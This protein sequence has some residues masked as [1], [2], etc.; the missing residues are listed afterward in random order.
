MT[1]AVFDTTTLLQ[2][3]TS[4]KGPAAACLAFVDEGHVRLF[5]SAVTLD[6]IRE[7]LNRPKIRKSF[8]K[9]TDENV[10]DF[11]DHL[12]DKGHLV[13][14]VPRAYQYERDPDDEPFLNLAI[15][16]QAPFIVSRDN[17]FL[18]LMKDEAFRKTYPDL[19]IVD[20]VA[21]LQYVR[22]EIAKK[23]GNP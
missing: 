1:S 16:A 15:A 18:D 4:R 19:S 8:P 17:D 14:D 2:A 10:L 20:P 21:F 12:V 13:E 11:L 22:D 23:P 7:V 6:E 5:V 9:L 3:A